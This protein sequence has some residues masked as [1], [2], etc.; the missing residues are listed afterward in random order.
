[1]KKVYYII[2]LMLL[3]VS[4][5]MAQDNVLLN[6]PRDHDTID[7]KHPMLS[8]SIMGAM[9]QSNG[10]QYYRLILVELDAEQSAA[11]GVT[12]NSP[13]LKIERVQGSQLFYPM[14]APELEAGKRYGWQVQKIANNMITQKSEA[15]EF[16]LRDKERK[17]PEYYRIST[18]AGGSLF[19]SQQGKLCFHLE[20]AHKGGALRYYV[21]NDKQQLL[22]TEAENLEGSGAPQ[23]S[24]NM[25]VTGS[26]FYEIDLG[27]FAKPG[28]YKLVVYD[29]RNKK[30][31]ANFKVN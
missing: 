22:N 24:I 2:T 18:T 28:V 7:E 11:A 19:P 25:R 3:S 17:T 6:I 20:E 21:Y 23:T 9:P 29:A 14:D 5:L 13:L 12:V 26:N 16:I 4:G 8:W 1:M 15:Y 10:R 30:Y 27:Q 31:E